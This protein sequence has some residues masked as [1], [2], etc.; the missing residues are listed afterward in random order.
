MVT[1]HDFGLEGEFD[2]RRDHAYFQ[3]F[4]LYDVLHNPDTTEKKQHIHEGAVQ[5]ACHN[6]LTRTLY[7]P[8]A[9]YQGRK[10]YHACAVV[11]TRCVAVASY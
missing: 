2:P 3:L 9:R 6:Q 7:T 4:F 11:C 10:Q 5:H 8:A 1:M